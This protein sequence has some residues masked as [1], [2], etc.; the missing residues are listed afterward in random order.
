MEENQTGIWR[1]EEQPTRNLVQKI[2][3]CISQVTSK[4]GAL[5]DERHF[6]YIDLVLWSS[7]RVG[8]CWA[9][10]GISLS[11]LPVGFFI[12]SKAAVHSQVQYPEMPQIRSQR[13]SKMPDSQD[14]TR[15]CACGFATCL[16]FCPLFR[17]SSCS[18]QKRLSKAKNC[19]RVAISIG[20]GVRQTWT[21]YT[22]I[23]T[24]CILVFIYEAMIESTFFL[25]QRIRRFK[26][27][28]VEPIA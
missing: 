28:T 10:C 8:H 16:K 1:T 22:E 20:F 18:F 6:S 4:I 9:L 19:K 27:C 5:G 13:K 11:V 17:G 2:K 26:D 24:L 3:C 25:L 23:F 7:D 14:Y 15:V 21:L 12:F